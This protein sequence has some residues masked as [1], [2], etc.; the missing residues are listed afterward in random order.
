[1]WH[2]ASVAR[3]TTQGGIINQQDCP[4]QD[5]ESRGYGTAQR[6]P[7]HSGRLHKT[8]YCGA[9]QQLRASNAQQQQGHGSMRE[10]K[11]T[12][13]CLDRTRTPTPTSPL[14][15]CAVARITSLLQW[16]AGDNVGTGTD[17]TI[18]SKVDGI[19]IYSKRPGRSLVRV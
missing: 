8:P 18:F 2:G 14:S 7:A 4:Q 1:M 3:S 16:H 5:A 15:C 6:R 9:K 10:G 13:S 12:L 17:F 11:P 19:V